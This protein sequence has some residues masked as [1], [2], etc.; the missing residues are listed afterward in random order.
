MDFI[1]FSSSLR[2]F[3][4]KKQMELSVSDTERQAANTLAAEAL[5]STLFCSETLGDLENIAPPVCQARS[6]VSAAQ[7]ERLRG[8]ATRYPEL[9]NWFFSTKGLIDFVEGKI[10]AIDFSNGYE[11]DERMIADFAEMEGLFRTFVTI[12]K[13][14]EQKCDDLDEGKKH[15]Q[16]KEA[17]I[18]WYE[19]A[20]G[21]LCLK[22]LNEVAQCNRDSRRGQ[23]TSY[24]WGKPEWNY[25]MDRIGELDPEQ[26]PK[27]WVDAAIFDLRKFLHLDVSRG[28][29]R[30]QVVVSILQEALAILERYSHEASK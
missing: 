20:M 24:A 6:E 26:N 12:Q 13:R 14:Y 11:E 17:L 3:D 21:N 10:K 9:Y 8:N 28:Y 30:E 19:A 27:K 15:P 5:G 16:I 25:V 2:A 29:Q 1:S 7:L 23:L 22:L 4:P 18:S